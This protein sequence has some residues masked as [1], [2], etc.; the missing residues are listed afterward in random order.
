MCLSF[1]PDALIVPCSQ[2]A[3]ELSLKLAEVTL[4]WAIGAEGRFSVSS[5]GFRVASAGRGEGRGRGRRSSARSA[6]RRPRRTT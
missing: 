5:G 6:S 4:N 2:P 1:G 3:T